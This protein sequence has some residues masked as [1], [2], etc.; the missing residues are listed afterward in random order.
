M[1]SYKLILVLKSSMSEADRK[2][3]FETFK[4]WMADLK[5]VRQEEWG[6]KTLT[7]TIKKEA[8]GFF[9]E[10][11]IEGDSLPSDFEKRLKTSDNVLRH[12]LLK[13]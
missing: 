3:F 2:K 11:H 13:N 7:Y 8:S 5:I 10:L 9:V 4:D 12:M 1:Q 6:Q